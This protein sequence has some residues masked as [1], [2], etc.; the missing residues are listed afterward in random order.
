MMLPVAHRLD[1]RRLSAFLA[2][3]QSVRQTDQAG[4]LQNERAAIYFLHFTALLVSGGRVRP[5]LL[6]S[7]SLS[8]CRTRFLFISWFG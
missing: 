3:K 8:L 1:E 4:G 6:S 5:C 2:C 7:L